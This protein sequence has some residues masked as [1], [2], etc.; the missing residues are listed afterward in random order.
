MRAVAGCVEDGEWSSRYHST[1]IVGRVSCS[2]SRERDVELTPG[3]HL[4]RQVDCDFLEV[5]SRE[6]STSP[7]RINKKI[8]N[9]LFSYWSFPASSH[10]THHYISH[11]LRWATALPF[12]FSFPYSSFFPVTPATNIHPWLPTGRAYPLVQDMLYS[13]AKIGNI[14]RPREMMP[15]LHTWRF[16]TEF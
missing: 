10:T 3:K 15:T 11:P 6:L 2:C 13:L 9:R 1:N 14:L 5:C 7:K 16:I 8:W 12:T 4:G